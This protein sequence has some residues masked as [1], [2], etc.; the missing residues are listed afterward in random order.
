MTALDVRTTYRAMKSPAYV[1][2]V[3]MKTWRVLLG[4]ELDPENPDPEWTRRVRHYWQLQR[5]VYGY[6]VGDEITIQ[7]DHFPDHGFSCITT[8]AKVVKVHPGERITSG[9]IS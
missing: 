4:L 1:G 2:E 8:S 9:S 5:D 3:R 7:S 6:E